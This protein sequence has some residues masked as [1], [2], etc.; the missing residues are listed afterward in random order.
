MYLTYEGY[1]N[2]NTGIDL[3]KDEFEAVYRYAELLVLNE[4]PRTVPEGNECIA[5]AIAF[6][7]AFMAQNGGAEGYL[8]NGLTSE[9]IG[10]YSYN[11][12][13]SSAGESKA[14]LCPI[15]RLALRRSGLLYTGGRYAE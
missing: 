11:A 14:S 6:Q 4:I 13:Q 15:A 7:V 12:G 1:C 3:E 8:S 9:T 5:E 2:H 10:S